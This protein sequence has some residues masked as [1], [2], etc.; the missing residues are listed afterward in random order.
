MEVRDGLEKGFTT[1]HLIRPDLHSAQMA[2]DR[3]VKS[4]DASAVSHRKTGPPRE[5]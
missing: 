2:Y 4:G 3:I 5:P 1:I